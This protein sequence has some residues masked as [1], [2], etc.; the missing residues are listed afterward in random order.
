MSSHS[1][2]ELKSTSDTISP[3]TEKEELELNPAPDGG[4]RAWLVAAGGSC[5]FFAA[6]G[7]A[8]SFGVFEEYYLTHQLKGQSTDKIAWI[9]SVASCFQF[10][11]GAIGGPLF[12]RFGAWVIRPCAVL[13]IFSIMMTSLCKEYWQ[14]MLAQGVLMGISMGL[15]QFPA[16]A[17]V[18]QFFDKKRAA[19]L[20]VVVAGSSIGGVVMPIA[21]SKMLNG[22]SLGFGWSVRIIGFILIPLLGF[23]CIAVTS[24]LPPRQSAFFMIEPF[25]DPRFNLVIGALFFMFI[26]MLAPLF[27]IPT[28]AVSR[29]MDSTMASYLLA[30]LNAA[31]TFGRIIPGVLADKFGRLNVFTIGGIVTGIV[32][33]CLNLPTSTAALVV[34]S[35]AVGFSSGT[36]ISGASSAFTVCIKRLQDAGTYLGMGIAVASVAALIGPPI[37]GA[38]ISHYGGY[39]QM[40][41]FSGAMTIVGGLLALGAKATTPEGIFGKI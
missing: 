36:I 35:I 28:Y 21:M 11:A 33:F 9:G 40:S 15:I 1:V 30:I 12:D 7:F 4:F 13:Y 34:Y 16:M 31:S 6:L 27:Y 38:L 37:N 23:S 22:T 19:A 41:Y 20:G 17:A 8:N 39:A 14:F 32:I 3:T 26:G 25:K 29:G 2:E 5:I 10:T 24:R 18:I